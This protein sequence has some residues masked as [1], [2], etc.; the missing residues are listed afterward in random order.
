MVKEGSQMEE[1]DRRWRRGPS[2][3]R[4]CVGRERK[5]RCLD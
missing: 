3:G 2:N 1:I 5:K 4:V